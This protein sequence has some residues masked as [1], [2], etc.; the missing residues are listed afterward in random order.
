VLRSSTADIVRQRRGS[1][2]RLWRI[3]RHLGRTAA[4]SGPAEPGRL[5]FQL[6]PRCSEEGVVAAPGLFSS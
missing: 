3:T 4:V 2:S 6:R 5:R 1:T